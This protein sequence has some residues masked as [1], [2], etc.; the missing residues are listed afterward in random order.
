MLVRY[1]LVLSLAATVF[2]LWFTG[3]MALYL[4]AKAWLHPPVGKAPEAVKPLQQ[5]GHEEED[6]D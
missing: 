1:L 6:E 3:L 2:W 5:P 4:R